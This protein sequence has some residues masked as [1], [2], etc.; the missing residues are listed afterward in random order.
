MSRWR[1][2]FGDPS[3]DTI[4]VDLPAVYTYLHVAGA[5][6]K[7]V[8]GQV[9]DLSDPATL[10]Q[11]VVLAVHEILVN[12][13]DHAYRDQ[14]G[15]RIAVSLSIADEPRR[16]LVELRDGGLAFDIDAVPEPDLDAPQVHGYGI[17]LARSLL[18]SV[19]YT[20][21]PGGNRWLL[22]KGL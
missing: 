15:G 11:R 17:F 16:L 3:P 9:P 18:D 21:T 14:P 5:C 6:I 13:V 22:V 7:E 4:R 12:I 19:S 1:A 20:S 10:S 8:L 2:G